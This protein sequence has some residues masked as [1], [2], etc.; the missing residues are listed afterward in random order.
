[1]H[2]NTAKIFAIALVVFWLLACQALAAPTPTAS[3]EPTFTP[4]PTATST[5]TLTPTPW[6]SGSLD[7]RLGG[8][9]SIQGVVKDTLG[10]AVPHA[11]VELAVYG[12]KAGFDIGLLASRAL[13]TDESG[14]YAFENVTRLQSGHYELWFNGGPEYGRA[15][16]NSG[17]Y[18][19]AGQVRNDVHKIN[20]VVRPVTHS[21]LQAAV[22]Y[23][24]A[25]GSTRRFYTAP[26]LRAEPGHIM[27]LWRGTADNK[28]YAI[29]AEHGRIEGEHVTWEGLAGGRYFLA[30]TYRMFDGIVA[31]CN[32][33]SF[34]I[35][36]G[37]TRILE[38]T[39][40][41]C[42]ASQ[43]PVLP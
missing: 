23:V 17:Y 29:G 38:Y 6:P 13:Y 34:E 2:S 39:I 20:V 22:R 31:Q 9:L 18:I 32:T 42:G 11:F 35:L 14:S 37:E 41:H 12:A 8:T 3:P 21:S 15:Y 36:P 1:M 26:F 16:E 19:Q 27:E 25:D 5:L 33:S 40:K 43:Q 24:D 7:T 30:F 28:E 4:R 10:A